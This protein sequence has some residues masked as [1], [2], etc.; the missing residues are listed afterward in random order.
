[1]SRSVYVALILSIVFS[2]FLLG[3][4]KKHFLIKIWAIVRYFIATTLLAVILYNSVPIV[5][6][7]I[8]GIYVFTFETEDVNLRADRI[9]R[10]TK[11]ILEKP[12]L[13][14]GCPYYSY[15]TVMDTDDVPTFYIYALAGGFPLLIV[16]IMWWGYMPFYF[17]KY[18]SKRLLKKEESQIIIYTSAS[19]VGGLIPM[20]T[21]WNE[22]SVV[23]MITLFGATYRYLIIK[24]IIQFPQRLKFNKEF[25]SNKKPKSLKRL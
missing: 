19:F 13:G 12:F 10:A 11:Y 9:P 4:Q 23:L 5:K 15:F 16:L 8:N 3:Y 18:L 1:M 7:I 6:T 14:H 2:I 20:I 17:T 24:K 21:N 25:V 22:S